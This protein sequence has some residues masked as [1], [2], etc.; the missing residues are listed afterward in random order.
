MDG[1]SLKH[2]MDVLKS[3][4]ES[5]AKSHQNIASQ[6]KTELEE[7]LG[8]F[9]GA[10]RERRKIVQGGVEKLLKQKMAQTN[11]VNKVN[12]W[13]Y[14]I[15]KTRKLTCLDSGPIWERLSI[16][17]ELLGTG[18]YGYGSRGEKKQGEA[19]KDTATIDDIECRIWGCHQGFDRDYWKVESRL[20]GCLRRKLIFSSVNSEF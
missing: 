1:G 4:M 20:E 17:Q 14:N 2:S 19:R 11:A 3:E 8:A 6:Y 5:M 18:A 12:I 13:C 16:D 7:P 15:Y 9:S 10:M